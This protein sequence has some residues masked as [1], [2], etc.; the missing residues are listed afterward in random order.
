MISKKYHGRHKSLTQHQSHSP[1]TPVCEH[2]PCKELAVP[3]MLWPWH[4][5]RSIA[6]L[7]LC[8][9][10][11]NV[12]ALWRPRRMVLRI[13]SALFPLWMPLFCP[14]CQPG[15]F[16]LPTAP[17]NPRIKVSVSCTVI[18]TPLLFPIARVIF[19]LF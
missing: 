8:A 3:L 16:R 12:G 15:S 10:S 18:M 11:S 1:R 7:R 6:L 2:V 19:L 17:H 9:I 13:C 14:A 4:I 5:H